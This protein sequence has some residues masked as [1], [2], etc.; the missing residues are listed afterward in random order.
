MGIE[1]RQNRINDI[2]TL[3]LIEIYSAMKIVMKWKTP[4]QNSYR[5]TQAKV[6][7]TVKNFTS[8]KD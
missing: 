1:I 7:K 2:V 4:L 8:P 6:N 3:S 5:I